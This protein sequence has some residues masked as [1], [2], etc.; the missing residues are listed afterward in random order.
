MPREDPAMGI[1]AIAARTGVNVSAIRFYEQKG[2]LTPTRNAGGQRRF[3][4][5][6]IRRL[7]FI[8]VAQRLGLSIA[9]IRDVLGRLPM[10]RTPTARDWQRISRAIDGHIAERIEELERTRAL[11]AG[12]IGCGCLSMERCKLYN[13]EDRAGAKGPG[14]RFILGD[15]WD[16]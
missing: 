12:C 3:R 4:R 11:L 10:E 5:S 13:P 14:P 7:S 16:V 8:L 6:D 15:R 2:L 1:G 9:E